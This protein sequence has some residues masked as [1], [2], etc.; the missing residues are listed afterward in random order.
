MYKQKYA[1]M[2]NAIFLFWDMMN[3]VEGETGNHRQVPPE[4]NPNKKHASLKNLRDS[5]D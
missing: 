3:R 2:D 4:G 5:R 1:E